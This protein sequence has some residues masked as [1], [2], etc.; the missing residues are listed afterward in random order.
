VYNTCLNM[1]Y[2]RMSLL[3]RLASANSDSRSK[4]I[5]ALG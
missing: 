4:V 3:L 2:I 5:E 1:G